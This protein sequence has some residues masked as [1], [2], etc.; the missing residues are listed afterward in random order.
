MSPSPKHL[1]SPG[2]C[3]PSRTPGGPPPC[4]ASWTEPRTGAAHGPPDAKHVVFLTDTALGV[5]FTFSVIHDPY[6]YARTHTQVSYHRGDGCSPSGCSHTW[7][8]ICTSWTST[9]PSP[10][11]GGRGRWPCW[12]ACPDAPRWSRSPRWPRHPAN[13]VA[14]LATMG[15]SSQ[16]DR[17]VDGWRQCLGN[18]VQVL[19][20]GIV[21]PMGSDGTGAVI[22]K[23]IALPIRSKH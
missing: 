21:Q 18:G 14:A 16:R 19:T 10:S 13:G 11:S 22:T 23:G 2:C 17:R 6:F 12:W 15:L 7:R 5:W 3:P 8:S 9:C 4:C 20:T 1:H